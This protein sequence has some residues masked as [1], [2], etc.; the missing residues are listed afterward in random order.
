MQIWKGDSAPRC[1]QDRQPCGA[2]REMHERPRQGDEILNDRPLAKLLDLDGLKW[3]CSGAQRA[4]DGI[5][6]RARG[7][8]NGDVSR[9]IA[10]ER[11]PDDLDY[12]F[13]FRGV[14]RI[15]ESV[16]AHVTV[17]FRCRLARAVLHGALL[18][19]AARRENVREHAIDPIDD[20]RSGA[21]VLFQAQRRS[22]E[23]RVGKECRS[24]WWG[25]REEETGKDK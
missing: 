23:R 6:V 3:D 18:R 11:F 2:I 16:H 17:G 5:D 7:Y 1:P 20:D 19:V 25:Y 14:V 10:C 12:A 24:R 15:D 22:E 8:E 21:K 9:L 13:G 4:R